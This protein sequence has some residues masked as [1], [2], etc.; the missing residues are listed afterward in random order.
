MML[1]SMILDSY[2]EGSYG[3]AQISDSGKGMLFQGGGS[4]DGLLGV[5]WVRWWKGNSANRV[6]LHYI[7]LRGIDY[8]V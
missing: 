4:W 2:G 8:D 6:T 1:G 3:N 7:D 5:V